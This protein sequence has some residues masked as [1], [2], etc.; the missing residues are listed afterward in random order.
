MDF[1][2]WN[3]AKLLAKNTEPIYDYVFLGGA[4]IGRA[5]GLSG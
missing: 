5:D 2:N 4:H 3:L 1:Y